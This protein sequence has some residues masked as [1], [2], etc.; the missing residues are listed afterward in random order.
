MITYHHTKDSLKRM[1]HD[2][3]SSYEKLLEKDES[4][5]IHSRSKGSIA[6][7]TFTI[8]SSFSGGKISDVSLRLKKTQ[9]NLA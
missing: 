2:N 8:K 5:S 4:V 9:Y 1:N 3:L 6:V 7:E